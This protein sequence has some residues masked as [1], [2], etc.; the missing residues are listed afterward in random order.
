M[1]RQGCHFMLVLC[2]EEEEGIF[3][4]DAEQASY[5]L[6]IFQTVEAAQAEAQQQVSETIRWSPSTYDERVGLAISRAIDISSS[7][8]I[9][10][11]PLISDG[12]T[13]YF[14]IQ[15]IPYYVG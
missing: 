8:Y 1:E 10:H 14:E 7:S 2:T 3:P 5:C 12:W 9:Q 11:H 6:A 4:C 13:G 15:A